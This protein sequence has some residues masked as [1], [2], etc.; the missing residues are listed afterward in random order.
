MPLRYDGVETMKL[1]EVAEA[2]DGRWRV[3]AKTSCAAGSVCLGATAASGFG[4]A[5]R[6]P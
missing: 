1:F 2:L 6:D 3:E 5:R 4:L